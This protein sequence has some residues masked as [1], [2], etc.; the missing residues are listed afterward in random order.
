MVDCVY[1]TSLKYSVNLS[2]DYTSED[3][4]GFQREKSQ[5]KRQNIVPHRI[6]TLNKMPGLLLNNVTIAQRNR[7]FAGCL[8]ITEKVSFKVAREALHLRYVYILSGKKSIKNGPILQVLEKLNLAVKQCNQTGQS[9][10]T[11]I[12]GKCQNSKAIENQRNSV[13]QHC[14][15][16]ELFL[17]FEWTKLIKNAKDG[18][19]W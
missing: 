14:E 17:H 12:G 18:P 3:K 10:R 7:K 9:N 16:S 8:K 11:K 4:S 19:I 6:Q 2:K 5:I 1:D 15:L 13:I